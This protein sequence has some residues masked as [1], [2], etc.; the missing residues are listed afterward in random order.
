MPEKLLHPVWDNRMDICPEMIPIK[1]ASRR[2]GLSYD[3]LRKSCLQKKIVHI[4]VGNGKFL[5]NYV[6]LIEWLE[7]SHGEEMGAG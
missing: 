4:R 2:T 1:E 5:I 7:T 3:Y 6:R